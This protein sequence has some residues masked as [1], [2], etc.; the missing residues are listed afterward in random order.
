MS[1]FNLDLLSGFD[2]YITPGL[3]EVVCSCM[4][5]QLILSESG[6]DQEAIILV[7]F[8]KF[9]EHVLKSMTIQLKNEQINYF[10]CVETPSI[11]NTTVSHLSSK[12]VPYITSTGYSAGIPSDTGAET[13][14]EQS[15][16]FGRSD[17]C[18]ISDQTQPKCH[19]FSEMNSCSSNVPGSSFSSQCVSI[20]PSF[21]SLLSSSE[22]VETQC[23]YGNCGI[24]ISSESTV[25]PSDYRFSTPPHLISVDPLDSTT[26]NGN[27]VAEML[28]YEQTLLGSVSAENYSSEADLA[29][30][31]ICGEMSKS[32]NSECTN[33]YE[34]H[35]RGPEYCSNYTR[36]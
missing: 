23:V 35:G 1:P 20:Q 26:Q 27:L 29:A 16:L 5:S 24:P 31:A 19:M 12:T 6:V 25:P 11:G 21:R 28:S 13:P 36:L 10:S 30:A 34:F 33:I 15:N 32:S 4:L 7:E 9:L 17:E 22:E 18:T 14:E 2:A 8:A 3:I